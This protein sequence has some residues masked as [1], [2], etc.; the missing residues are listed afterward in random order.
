MFHRMIP[1]PTAG[2]QTL[3]VNARTYTCPIGSTVDVPD[4]DGDTLEANGWTK[5]A[6]GGA[7]TTAQRPTTVFRG[8]AYLDTTVG[9]IIRH[10]GQSWRN[11]ATGAAV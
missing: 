8:L 11:P 5:A 4:F 3:A 2:R 10:D 6:E 9:F 1:P 7:G